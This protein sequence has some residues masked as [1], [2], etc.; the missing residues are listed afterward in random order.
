M[1]DTV[2]QEEGVSFELEAI[3]AMGV[4]Y[5][6]VLAELGLPDQNGTGTRMVAKRII[7]LAVQGERDPE[8]LKAVA[9]EGFT[10]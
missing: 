2:L 10:E 3:S 8:R 7:A 9:L 6:A 1:L 4:A 5:R